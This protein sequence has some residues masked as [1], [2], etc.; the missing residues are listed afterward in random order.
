[1]L[2]KSEIKKITSCAKK[3]SIEIVYLFGSSLE[4][5]QYNNDID[6]AVKGIA[7]DKFFKFYSE[8]SRKLAKPIDIID[9]S[10]KTTFSKIIQTEGK[11]IYGKLA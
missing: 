10:D 5:N 7:P 6:I 3:Y 11:I 2:S 1:M 9:L 4:D 8:L